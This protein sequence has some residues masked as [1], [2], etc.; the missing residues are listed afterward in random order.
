MTRVSGRE[1]SIVVNGRAHELERGETVARLLERLG[2]EGRYALVERNREPVERER[3]DETELEKGD[4]VV[5]ARPV[6]G[7]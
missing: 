3:F 6:A 1:R 4:E 5:V 2:F 7:G